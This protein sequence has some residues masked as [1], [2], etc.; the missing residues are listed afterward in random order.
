MPRWNCD[1]ISQYEYND[2]I[3]DS[4]TVASTVLHTDSLSLI[5]KN[6]PTWQYGANV[7]GGTAMLQYYFSG[8]YSSQIGSMQ[9]PPALQH[10]I[11]R[12]YGAGALNHRNIDP[13]SLNTIGLQSNLTSNVTK[14]ITVGA[15]INYTHVMQNTS[16]RPATFQSAVEGA[17]VPPGADSALGYLLNIYRINSVFTTSTEETNRFTGSGEGTYQP[18]DWLS[19][20]MTIG[21]D[22]DNLQ[23][24]LMHPGGAV[25][26]YDRGLVKDE[27]RDNTNRNMSLR[28]NAKFHPGRWSFQTAIGTQ[29][30]YSRMD[31]FTG[32]G[33]DLPVNSVSIRLA[34][35]QSLDQIWD[36]HAALGT[37]IDQQ[38][39]LNDRMYLNGALRVDGSTTFGDAYHPRPYPKFGVSW[40][41]SE[42]P[43]MRWLS[44]MQE[45]RFRYAY[46][47][48]SKYPTSVMKIGQL[49]GDNVTIDGQTFNSFSWQ[50]LANPD[51]R[52]ERSNEHEWGTDM[53]LLAG[54]HAELTWY[55]KRVTDELTIVP[56]DRVGMPQLYRNGATIDA[57]G[58]ESTITVPLFSTY[59][60][61]GDISFNYTDRRTRVVHLPESA[62]YG[63]VE[64]YPIDAL[65]GYPIV[66]YADTVGGHADGIIVSS[67]VIRDTVQRYLGVS[68]PPHTVTAT[69]SVSLLNGRLRISSLFDRETGF[70]V[71]DPYSQ[72]CG[73]NAT[74]LAAFLTST[75]PLIQAK[76]GQRRYEDFLMPGN[77]TRW[78]ELN[79]AVDVPQRFLRFANATVSVQGRNLRLWT[80]YKGLDPESR[81][82][83]GITASGSATA[84]G[85]P[86]TQSWSFRFDITP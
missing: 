57:H 9:M 58:L 21:M 15:S 25:N 75:P 77:F 56:Q 69:P 46:G 50:Y 64:G 2:C 42:E 71:N 37:F 4:I 20:N 11:V 10:L 66:G 61:R 51:I 38:I 72:D 17:T 16:A 19:A 3:L 68:S 26:Q 83:R 53:T 7:S 24:H 62:G 6:R 76:F 14:Q 33:Y 67:E 84:A 27:R 35:T 22:L 13:N 31:G 78:R 18:F 44:A 5:A 65:F 70:I 86:Q 63:Q 48:A 79:I 8:N 41:A 82:D 39:G 23:G 60:A 80:S 45:L 81:S 49:N 30:D 59:A 1:L 43:W 32:E 55:R 34:R 52:P 85:I 73:Q 47:S 12:Q 54:I 40:I 28:A 36:E 74:C 29:Y